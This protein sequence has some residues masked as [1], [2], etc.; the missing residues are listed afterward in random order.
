MSEG[1]IYLFIS[2]S[3]IITSSSQAA[4]KL[5]QCNMAVS[6]LEQIRSMRRAWL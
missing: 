5:A 4:H 1:T 6:M 3:F 2:I